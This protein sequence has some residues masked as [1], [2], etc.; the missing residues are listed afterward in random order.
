MVTPIKNNNEK[1][2]SQ[3][4][5]MGGC[6][7]NPTN[8]KRCWITRAYEGASQEWSLGVTFHVP[9][10]VGECEGMNPTLPTATLGVGILMD[11]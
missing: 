1:V 4:A 2:I 5:C 7:H 9:K 6:N 3:H 11:F 8:Q 10:S